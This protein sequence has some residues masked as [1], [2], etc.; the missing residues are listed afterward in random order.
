M[1]ASSVIFNSFVT[2]I[3]M[4]D[5]AYTKC[6]IHCIH[7]EQCFIQKNQENIYDIYVSIT[8]SILLLGKL[9]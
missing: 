5:I 4:E 8:A 2:D 1:L 6:H 9:Q 7:L 3:Y